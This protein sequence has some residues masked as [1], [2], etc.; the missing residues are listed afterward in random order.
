MTRRNEP[1]D[2]SG[3]RYGRAWTPGAEWR[4][5]DGYGWRP[6]FRVELSSTC[7]YQIHAC[8]RLGEPRVGP[9]A[10]MPHDSARRIVT[11]FN[12]GQAVFARMSHG[13]L[14][15]RLVAARF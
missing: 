3:A 14:A 6:L 2:T 4:S 7:L 8:R 13:C 11:A 1:A 5:Q 12:G 15:V 9:S 10:S